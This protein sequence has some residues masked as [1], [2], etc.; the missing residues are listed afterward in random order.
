M[1][2]ASFPRP[3]LPAIPTLVVL[4][5]N[6]VAGVIVGIIALPLSIA[7]AVAVG[8]PPV[9]G[10]YTAAFA[11][12]AASI[13]GG[14]N[15][16]ITGPTAAL[17]PILAHVVLVHGPGALAMVGVMAGIILIGLGLL[18]LGRLMR[19]MPGL[20]IVGF[21][22]GI[23]LS[24]AFGQLNNFLAVKDTDPKLEQFHEKAWDTLSHLHTL[25]I[26]TPAVGLLSLALLVVWSRSRRVNR[27]PAALVAVV[28]ATA[29]TWIFGIDTPTLAS[30]YG[31]LPSSFPKP[32]LGFFDAGEIITLLPTAMAVAILGAI[33]SLLSAVVADS[34]ASPDTTH[35]PNRELV[36]Q[37]IANLVSPVMGGIP[38]TAAIARTAAGIRNGA[39][40]RLTGVFHAVTV[41]TATLLVGSLAGHV[42]LATL[43]AVLLLVAWNIAEAAE[44]VRLFRRAPR[45]DLIVLAS[46]ILI[47]LFFDLSYAIGFGV[48][49]SA[50]LL[51]RRLTRLPAA[52]E[53]L[54]DE[55]GRIQRV[56]AELSDMMNSRPDIAF[57]TAQG[58][59]SFH[60]AATFEYELH[61]AER[62][63][64]IL[65][66]KDVHHVDTTGLLTLEGIIEHRQN[67][68][69]RIILTAIQA[70]L[71]PVL[72]RFGIIRLLGPENV[73]E[74]TRD[75]IASIDAPEGRT[76]H[77]HTLTPEP[78]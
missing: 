22:A 62:N 33:E 10:L 39:T 59:L 19:Y 5:S 32:S 61:G 13:F 66:M 29:V 34:M 64:L 16:N 57:F 43:A 44:V 60:S 35:D 23:A 3:T 56:S 47:T 70:D 4:Q 54:P 2:K 7:L 14:S 67:N 37:G 65:R 24:I 18:R 68:G 28:A 11:G 27:I 26:T 36:G 38:S 1:I 52:A 9:A 72:D 20:V 17:V 58:T 49:A 45:E 75:A 41:I 12:A 46:T 71:Y 76:I 78:A 30:R 40:S 6:L 25:G 21:T 74:H 53:L 50:V 73:F 8:V 31:D 15:Y 48:L 69:R 51:L 42:P 63:P 55:T 77:P